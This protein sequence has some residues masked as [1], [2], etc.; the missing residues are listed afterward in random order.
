MKKYNVLIAETNSKAVETTK[1]MLSNIQDLN[2]VDVVRTG[3]EAINAVRE[4]DIDMVMCDL[5][6]QG[7]DGCGVVSVIKADPDI[8]NKPFCV[9]YSTIYNDIVIDNAYKMGSDYFLVKPFSDIMVGE[10]V[11]LMKT[12]TTKIEPMHYNKDKVLHDI[13]KLFTEIGLSNRIAGYGYLRDAVCACIENPKMLEGVT[14]ILYPELDHNKSA[15]CTERAM[16]YAI[17]SVFTK[18]NIES[19]EKVFGYRGCDFDKP[20]VTEF[21]ACVSNY[22]MINYNM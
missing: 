16:R 1:Q 12:K 14:K 3:K 9:I 13:T 20:S 15:S 7:I 21:I 6:T 10:L 8:K 17:E 19:L 2:I 11:R 4:N 22:I 18:G 5:Y